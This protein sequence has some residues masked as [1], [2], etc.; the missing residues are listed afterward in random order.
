LAS[1][2]KLFDLIRI[3]HFRGFEAFWEIPGDV[4]DARLGRWVKAPGKAFLSACF[5]KY[6]TLPLVAE[7]LGVITEEVE[8]LR[9]EFHLPGMLVLQFGFDGNEDNPHLPHLH[10]LLDVIYTGTHDNDT[11]LGWYESL[12]K[13]S[14]EQ[15]SNYLFNAQEPMPWLLIKAA[16]SSVS[17]M[18]IIPMQDLL[19]LDGENRMNM[20]GTTDKNWTWCFKWEQVPK[21]LARKTRQLLKL[22][23]RLAK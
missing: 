12:N 17:R 23:G 1:Q 6:Q 2:L 3:D 11:T 22:Y 20:P 21:E 7:N 18:V 16:L 13:S 4:K 5:N 19:E 8:Q 15:L 10:G 14:R 9:H